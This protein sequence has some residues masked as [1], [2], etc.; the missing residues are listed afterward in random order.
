MRE[1]PVC[2]RR[3]A[4][5]LPSEWGMETIRGFVMERAP[6][7][8]ATSGAVR[9]GF[10]RMCRGP[11][12]RHRSP[13]AI[14]MAGFRSKHL[15]ANGAHHDRLLKEALLEVGAVTLPPG[16]V[17]VP[18]HNLENHEVVA[19]HMAALLPHAL[20]GRAREA[21][22]PAEPVRELLAHASIG[23]ALESVPRVIGERQK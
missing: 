22:D 11:E 21:R 20:R 18:R 1:T 13:D 19:A 9:L 6:L 3:V 15:H 23:G 2:R 7:S 17:D 16:P 8:N 12:R 10:P 4:S 5:A 14:G